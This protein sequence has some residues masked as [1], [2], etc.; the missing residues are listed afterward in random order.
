MSSPLPPSSRDA[1]INDVVTAIADVVR[2]NYTPPDG[3]NLDEPA[4]TV[5]EHAATR[6]STAACDTL[7]R[8]L[9]PLTAPDDTNSS[10]APLLPATSSARQ[11]SLAPSTAVAPTAASLLPELASLLAQLAVRGA[12]TS[13]SALSSALHGAPPP[14]QP[15]ALDDETVS[16]L[17]SQAVSILNIKALVPITLDLAAGNY[18]RW[19][20]LFLVVLGKYTLT[21]HIILDTPP[22]DQPDWMQMDCVVLG[23]L[24]GRFPPTF[25]KKSCR[26]PRRHTPFGAISRISSSGTRNDTPSISMPSSAPSRK[27]ISPSPTIAGASS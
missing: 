4:R 15:P 22:P 12:P 6:A 20:G 16:T 3:S 1:L 21:D 2:A 8:L 5:A 7:T 26:P 19:R 25:S 13:S 17:H 14:P 24:Y 23:W 9:P 11:V 18:T 10:A 27:T